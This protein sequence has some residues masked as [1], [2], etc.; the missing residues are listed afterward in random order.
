MTTLVVLL[1]LAAIVKLM[2]VTVF[3]G[4]RYRRRREAENGVGGHF[5]ETLSS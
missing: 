4:V 5:W 3:A 2:L 1:V